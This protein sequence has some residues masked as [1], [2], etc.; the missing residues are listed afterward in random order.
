[1]LIKDL[2]VFRSLFHRIQWL[3]ARK[4]RNIVATHSKTL[5]HE[6]IQVFQLIQ[7]QRVQSSGTLKAFKADFE[8]AQ[9]LR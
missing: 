5:A 2:Q 4:R 3:P 7:F 1:V 6:L 9:A 8:A